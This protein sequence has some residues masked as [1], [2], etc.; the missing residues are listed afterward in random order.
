[1]CNSENRKSFIDTI[2]FNVVLIFLIAGSFIWLLKKYQSAIKKLNSNSQVTTEVLKLAKRLV[3]AGI[4]FSVVTFI[5]ILL[6]FFMAHYWDSEACKSV[7]TFFTAAFKAITLIAAG[8]SLIEIATLNIGLNFVATKV[9]VE[10]NTG[11]Y[12]FEYATFIF[13]AT[14]LFAEF[15][16]IKDVWL[17]K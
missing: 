11:T 5:L 16:F 17:S 10:L 15:T 14:I 6:A 12:N 1:M 7:F 8:F 9:I 4:P 3:N 13:P 2:T